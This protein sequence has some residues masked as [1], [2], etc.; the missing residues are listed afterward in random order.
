MELK[1]VQNL[2]HAGRFREALEILE[3]GSVVGGRQIEV[4]VLKAE[5]LE[6]TGQYDQSRALAEKLLRN[7]GL[8]K[9]DRSKC[10]LCLGLI[11]WNA[12]DTETAPIHFQ[13]AVSLAEQA[14]DA[15]RISWSQLRLAVVVAGREG[16]AAVVPLVAKAGSTRQR[17][18]TQFLLQHYTFS[19][20]KW[21]LNEG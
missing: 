8:G 11:G 20:V 4:G 9:A 6:R 16:P 18:E 15:A 21:K 14:E 13:R 5:L 2:A 7:P 3:T 19:S 1:D 12:G 10:E 17:P